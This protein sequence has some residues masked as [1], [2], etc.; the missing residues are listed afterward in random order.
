M[1]FSGDDAITLPI[2]LMGG[3]GVISVL[4]QALPKDF[5]LWLNTV[6]REI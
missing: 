6:L 4:A 5:L 1:V 2:I 3:D